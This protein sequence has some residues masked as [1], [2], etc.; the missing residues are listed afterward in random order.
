MGGTFYIFQVFYS[1]FQIRTSE[2]YE[3]EVNDPLGFI[4]TSF[5]V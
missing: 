3:V 4:E 1:S 5:G 2:A